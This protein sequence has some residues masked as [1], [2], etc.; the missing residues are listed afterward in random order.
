MWRIME[1]RRQNKGWSVVSHRDPYLV[2]C[3]FCIVCLYCKHSRAILFADDTNLFS[4]GKYLKTLE[5]TTNNELWNISLWLKVNKLSL[6][7]KKTHY[8]IFRRRQKFHH[9]V[10]LLIDGEAIDKVE[11]TK[12]LGIIIDNK[13]TRK[14]HIDHIAGKISHVI[15]MI[16]KARQYLNKSGLISLYYS[17]I[18]PH[19][20][21]CNHIWEASYKTRL[22]RLVMLQNKAVRI[23]LHAGNRTSSDPLH[24]KRDI[25]KV[26]NINTYLIGRFMF[27]VSIDKVPQSIRSLLKKK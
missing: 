4:S 13:L 15:G 12:F 11:K 20:T 10:K 7:T 1:Y 17:F 2:L 26:E 25:M 21:Y 9:N 14:W 5:S 23:S 3:Y 27:C 19:L 16:I 8:M 18:Y 24:K 6:N 22:K